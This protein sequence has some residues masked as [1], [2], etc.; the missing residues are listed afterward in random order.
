[1][2]KIISR[3]FSPSEPT[4][5]DRVRRGPGD[6]YLLYIDLLYCF[7]SA[8]GVVEDIQVGLG[9]SCTFSAVFP[10]GIAEHPDKSVNNF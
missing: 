8:A 6:V 4:A 3:S 2:G 9:I 10:P 5:M 7:S 1:M